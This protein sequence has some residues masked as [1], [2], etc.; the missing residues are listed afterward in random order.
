MDHTPKG[1]LRS[2]YE[3]FFS[4][5]TEILE[6]NISHRFRHA[7]QFN[8]QELQ[9]LSLYMA[10]KC[11]LRPVKGDLFYLKPKKGGD[12]IAKKLDLFSRNQ[13]FKFGCLNSL[14]MATAEDQKMVFEWIKQRIG[15]LD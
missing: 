7:S 11:E 12:Y 1:L 14:D 13:N 2:F 4:R 5:H 15:L 8:P 9:Y 10:N 3:E 6:R